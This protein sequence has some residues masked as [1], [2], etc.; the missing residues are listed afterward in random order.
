MPTCLSF[1]FVFVFVFLWESEAII[2]LYF[3]SYYHESFVYNN[4]VKCS[5]L[6]LF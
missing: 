1:V 3:K 6:S 5:Q 2:V 4:A